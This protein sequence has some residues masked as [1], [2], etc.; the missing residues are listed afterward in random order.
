MSFLDKVRQ[1]AEEVCSR[2]QCRLYDID[3]VST[4]RRTLRV[5]IERESGGVSVDDCANVSQGLNLM[6]D[7]DDL[8]PG[9][10]YDLEVSSP[11]LERRLREWWHYQGAVGKTIQVQSKDDA[12][13]LDGRLLKVLRGVL[14]ELVDEG[15]VLKIER[16]EQVWSVPFDEVSKAKV[17]FEMHNSAP[18]KP[19]K[20]KRV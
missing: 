5:Y 1:I 13:E 17:V 8:I 18:S 7:V 11:G 14:V 3:F 15:R 2:E 16:Q 12:F 20:K 6:L 9:G 4:G 19:T 10:A